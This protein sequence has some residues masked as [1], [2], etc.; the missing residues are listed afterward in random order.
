MD[1]NEQLRVVVAY[2]EAGHAVAHRYM[3][4]WFYWITIQSNPGD[5]SLGCV[6]T[7]PTA[8]EL[9]EGF[10]TTLAARLKAEK[11]IVGLYGGEAATE[12]LGVP[13]DWSIPEMQK[14]RQAAIRTTSNQAEADAFLDYLW[15]WTQNIIADHR[16]AVQAV[17]N[18]LL[19]EGSMSA[20]MAH[21]VMREAGMVRG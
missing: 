18:Y 8:A 10:S 15:L 3:H 13:A 6:H 20:A 7:A 16:P 1:E 14:A 9:T 4:H 11:E 2:H 12:R 19:E 21:K 17:A 5:K